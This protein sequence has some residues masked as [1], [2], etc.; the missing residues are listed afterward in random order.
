M[1]NRLTGDYEFAAGLKVGGET[2]YLDIAPDGTP[3][4]AGDATVF[5]DLDFAMTFR[6]NASENPPVWTQLASTGI[7]A[8]Q[9]WLHLARP[10]ALDADHDGHLHRHLDADLNRARH[11]RHA[12]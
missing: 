1:A 9:D 6:S 5:D 4:L 8:V 7:Y 10:C 2:A 12:Q 11:Q 3:T